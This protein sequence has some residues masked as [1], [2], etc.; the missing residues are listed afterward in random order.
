[1]S[2]GSSSKNQPLLLQVKQSMESLLLAAIA[3]F[4]MSLA[5]SLYNRVILGQ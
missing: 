5:I 1:M 4:V 2:P 3:L